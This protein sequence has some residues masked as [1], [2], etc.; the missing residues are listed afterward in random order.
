MKQLQK[1]NSKK[2]FETNFFQ[3]EAKTAPKMPISLRLV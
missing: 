3:K 2:F 1:I